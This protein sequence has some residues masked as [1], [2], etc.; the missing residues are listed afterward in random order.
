MNNVTGDCNNF[1]KANSIYHLN[2]DNLVAP[3]QDIPNDNQDGPGDVVI[4]ANE[5]EQEAAGSE[6]AASESIDPNLLED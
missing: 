2:T 3:L 6:N 1:L 5:G 4:L